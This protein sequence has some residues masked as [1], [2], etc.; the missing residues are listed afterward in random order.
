M[1]YLLD[2]CL[3]IN[4]KGKLFRIRC[5]F[6]VKVRNATKSQAHLE[7]VVERIFQIDE[8]IILFE[9]N[10]AEVIHSEYDLLFY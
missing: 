6:K 5:P 4:Q 8:T 10:N 3:F 9:I 7:Y 1:K 2:S